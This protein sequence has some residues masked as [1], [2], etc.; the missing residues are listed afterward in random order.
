MAPVN[1]SK[2]GKHQIKDSD[3]PKTMESSKSKAKDSGK[4]KGAKPGCAVAAHQP[5]LRD[6]DM[7]WWY[8]FLSKQKERQA[9]SVVT[10]PVPSD[11]EE[12]FRYFFRTSRSTFDY[13]CSIV[14]DDL[15]SR[16]P[17]GLINI[18]GRLL[19]V[20]KQVGIA[21]RRLASRDSQVSVGAAFGVGQSTVSQVT[22]RFI[23]S[24]EERARHQLVWLDQERM[25]DIKASFEVVSGLPNCCGAI[26]ATHIVMTLPAVDSSED[27]CD[28]AKNYSMFL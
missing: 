27:W 26:D 1:K 13:I 6:P 10:A 24:M 23:E 18:E 9:D 22:W 7:E 3:N 21:M 2:K 16:P 5:D 25:D 17:S 14:R 28:H 8:A 19:S 20:E 4:F 15:I 12:A 11:E